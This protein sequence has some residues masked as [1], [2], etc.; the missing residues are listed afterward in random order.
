MFTAKDWINHLYTQRSGWFA[1]VEITSLL[2]WF[3]LPAAAVAVDITL[4]PA[5]GSVS[6]GSVG[7]Y[8]VAVARNI[9]RNIYVRFPACRG[10]QS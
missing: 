8:P 1:Y 9:A 3:K 5:G 2:F 7:F 6:D 10:W 4:F